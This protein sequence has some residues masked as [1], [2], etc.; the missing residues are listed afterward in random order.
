M[1]DPNTLQDA[2]SALNQV[3][4]G[5]EQLLTQFQGKQADIEAN[6]QAM[7]DWQTQPG[8]VQFKDIAGN[9][10]NIPTLKALVEDAQTVNPNPHVMT[11][12]EFDALR[13]MRKQQY[14]GSGFV[15]W[16]KHYDSG[17]NAEVVNEGMD[18]LYGAQYLNFFKLGSKHASS[19]GNSKSHLPTVTI[20]GAILKLSDGAG[21]RGDGTAVTNGDE[22][23]RVLFPPAPDGTKTYD[24]ATG[25]VTQHSNAEVAFA[26]ETDTNKVIT[27]RKDLVFLEAWHEKIADKDVIYPLGNVQYGANSY[28]S[29][30]LLN[31]LVAQGYSAFGEWDSNTKG[32]GVK[33]SSLTDEQKA[34]F[35]GE[36]AHNIYYDPK[37]KAY[38]QVRYRVRV[39]EGPGDNWYRVQADGATDVNQFLGYSSSNQV[40][41]VKP[42]GANTELLDL[43]SHPA[44][45]GGMYKTP[46]TVLSNSD[47]G[48]GAF[49]AY[50]YSGSSVAGVSSNNKCFALPIAL[51]QRLN[52]GAYHPSYNPMGCNRFTKVNVGNYHWYSLPS[53]FI[54]SVESCFKMGTT[55]SIGY[56]ST[57]G[58]IAGGDTGRNDQYKYCDAIYAGQV[59]DLRINANKLDV[60]KLR[61][62]KLS[63]AIA[64]KLRGKEKLPFTKVKSGFCYDSGMTI[65]IFQNTPVS[66]SSLIGSDKYYKG[67]DIVK[68]YPKYSE[69]KASAVAIKFTDAG[70]TDLTAFA[71]GTPLGQWFIIDEFSLQSDSFIALLNPSTGNSNWFSSGR[72]STIQAELLF[73]TEQRQTEFDALPWTDIIATPDNFK[74]TF[75]DGV[76]GQWIP[77]ILDGS[78]DYPLNRKLLGGSLSAIYSN[79]LGQ[80]WVK[81]D[82]SF[83][84]VKNI[85]SGDWDPN[86]VGLLHYETRSS[87]T[88]SSS[89]RVVVGN[90]GQVYASQASLNDYG[91]RLHASLTDNIG[92][93]TSTA[94]FQ[95]FLSLKK[96]TFFSPNQIL[97]WTSQV[98]DEPFHEPLSLDAPNDNSP[99]FKTLT[100]VTKKDGLLYMQFHGAEL[101]Y[102]PINL[103]HI[104]VIE[105][106]VEA[107]VVKGTVY[108]L[109]GFDNSHLN[110]PVIALQDRL[111]FTFSASAFDGYRVSHDGRIITSSG[112]EYQLLRVHN[113]EW[114]DDQTIPIISR[115][116]TK[117]DLNGNTVKVF[118]HHTMFPIGIAHN[119]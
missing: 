39:I 73:P 22:W 13:E 64:G 49:V 118:C 91:N 84:S 82:A 108:R 71:G 69:F 25:T 55:T 97:G 50:Q 74:A 23:K 57:F 113:N 15:E 2:V 40:G 56:H 92:K 33:W 18:L 34:V 29:I 30:T 110:R 115:E 14:A 32:Y 87:F 26:S 65:Y 89:N 6:N 60:N 51:V 58:K 103:S 66:A 81:S 68:S 80:T 78:P 19:T 99:A 63:D 88:H 4:T 42:Q 83:D 9:T 16:G 11:K 37:A 86:A 96:Y 41:V 77:K 111:N 8:T 61:E 112:A 20:D 104:E 85:K 94:Y 70:D 28:Q 67:S 43:S 95:E 53:D 109:K 46:F 54:P 107:S 72:A 52:L 106:G 75:P 7:Q 45:N 5:Q 12:A 116:N 48:L 76:Q 1:A 102:R 105:A 101:I 100:T 62:S 17:V 35:L 79:D 36:P 93:R 114:G 90:L 117:V 38:I 24:S 47:A 44:G 3:A 31:N 59:E 21:L 119:D 10:H 27:S 98:G